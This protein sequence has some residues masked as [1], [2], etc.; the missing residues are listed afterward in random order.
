MSHFVVYTWYL[1]FEL[2]FLAAATAQ[3]DGLP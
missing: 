2:L 3:I 1:S